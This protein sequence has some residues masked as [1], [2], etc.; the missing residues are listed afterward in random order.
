MR[1]IWEYL[2]LHIR[3]DF[4]GRVYLLTGIF[5]VIAI[6]FNYSI[7]FEDSYLDT[8]S[9]EKRL[10]SYFIW[11]CIAFYVPAGIGYACGRH[12]AFHQSGFWWRSL[13]AIMLLSLDRALPY[14][15]TFVIKNFS[16]QSQLLAFKIIH[17]IS[18]LF[19]LIVPLLLFYYLNDRDQ[20]HVYG[21]RPGAFDVRPYFGMILL[22]LPLLFSASFVPSFQAQYPMYQ[23]S[24]AAAYWKIPEWV[25]VL[26]Y[27]VAYGLNFVG[28]EFFYRGFLILGMAA[29]LGR[30]SVLCMASLYCFLH[31]GKPLGEAV[32]SIF[33]GYILGVIAYQT[34]SIWGGIIVHVGI[35]WMMEALGALQKIMKS[36]T[37]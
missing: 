20:R 31:F 6:A 23:H 10:A 14:A 4:H 8:H 22:M 12:R 3:E 7:D 19:L 28:I 17:N 29:L 27:E 11:H 9:D 18:G 36:C 2:L 16:Y 25:A 37:T 24:P 35:A 13:L 33:G 15:D 30:S 32:S 1:K 21:L 34:H 26:I 5:L